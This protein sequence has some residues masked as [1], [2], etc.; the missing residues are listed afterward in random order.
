MTERKLQ[1]AVARQIEQTFTSENTRKLFPE[2]QLPMNMGETPMQR[3]G[4]IVDIVLHSGAELK[5]IKCQ[6]EYNHDEEFSKDLVQI[7]KTRKEGGIIGFA[8]VVQG[9]DLRAESGGY[10]LYARQQYTKPWIDGIPIW[11]S[12]S[13]FETEN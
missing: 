3:T 4:M 11:E 6:R 12:Q 13:S 8:L 2:L 9:F 10:Y 5:G 7:S 1:D